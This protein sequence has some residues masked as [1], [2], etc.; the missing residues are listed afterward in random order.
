MHASAKLTKGIPERVEANYAESG[1][2]PGRVKQELKQKKHLQTEVGQ[3]NIL[4]QQDLYKAHLPNSSILYLMLCHNKPS[5]R[6]VHQSILEVQRG[7]TSTSMLIWPMH[8]YQHLNVH[9]AHAPLTV[10][11][12]INSSL[13]DRYFSAWPFPPCFILE[14]KLTLYTSLDALMTCVTANVYSSLPLTFCLY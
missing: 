9:M 13:R 14:Q 2:E 4:F 3:I 11:L 1:S 7:S 12:S 8:L 6:K 10:F 5:K